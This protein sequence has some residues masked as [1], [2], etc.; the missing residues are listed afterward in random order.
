MARACNSNSFCHCVIMVTMPVSWGRGL[1][2][3]KYT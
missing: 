2:S 1:T 3:L